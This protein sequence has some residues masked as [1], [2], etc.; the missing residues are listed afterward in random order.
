VL[1][2]V[3][4]FAAPALLV[5]CGGGGSGSPSPDPGPTV[6]TQAPT[7]HPSPL[8]TPKPSTSP[9]RSPSPAPTPS[10][11]P[12][13]TA[14]PSPTPSAL[15]VTP[16]AITFTDKSHNDVVVSLS[17]GSGSYAV[18]VDTCTPQGIAELVPPQPAPNQWDVSYGANTGSC[19]I[20]FTDG[21]T[22]AQ[23]SVTNDYNP[24]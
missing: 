14:T 20:A 18:G 11:L 8:P 6:P 17:G 1:L 3:L 24:H 7:R 23:L 16:S 15:T 2:A 5:A 22:S 13:A 4:V 19:T 12:T 21:K 9:T 10:S